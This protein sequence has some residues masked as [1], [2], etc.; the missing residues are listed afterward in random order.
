[1]AIN[2]KNK[3]KMQKIVESVTAD[4]NRAL[5]YQRP[6]FNKFN[7]YYQMYRSISNDNKQNYKGRANLFVP[8]AY[9]TVETIMPKLIGGRPKIE[10]IPREAQDMNSATA[11]TKLTDYQWDMMNMKKITKNW[12][13]QAL[14]YGVGIMK[15]VWDAD[16]NKPKAQEIDLF[17]F[18][19]DPNATSIGNASYIIHRG[20][21]FLYDIKNNPNYNVPAELEADVREDEYK[22]ERD[23]IFGL[24]KP[25]NR[26]IKSVEILEYWGMYD[27]DDEQG[28]VPSLITIA[29]Q[30]YLLRAD[31]N[32]YAHQKKPFIDFH[33]TQVPQMFWSIGEIEP[34]ESLQYEL[35]DTRNQRMDNVNLILNRMWIVDKNADVDEEEL[36]SRPGG[37]VHTMKMKGIEPLVPPDVTASSY[38]EESLI[39][40]DIQQTS[41]VTDVARGQ[42][43]GSGTSGAS[44]DTAT[45]ALILQEASS[46][47]FKYKLDNLEDSIREFGKQLNALNAQFITED[48]AVRVLGAGGPVWESISPDDIQKEYDVMV[49]AGSTQPMNRSVRRAEARE[50]IATIAPFVQSGII[51]LQYFIKHLLQQYDLTEIEEALTQQGIGISGQQPGPGGPPTPQEVG[52]GPQGAVFGGTGNRPS[53]ATIRGMGDR[54]GGTGQAQG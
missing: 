16:E 35:N 41:G 50:L 14:I 33:D 22:V 26:S 1:M 43:T 18:F 2:P 5:E 49:E 21:K 12:V 53:N 30:R 31:R 8:Y 46:N 39:K 34:I 38:N 24:S 47:R 20:E 28:P 54:A 27:F 17:D 36:V 29:N 3:E 25:K 42:G 15:L 45:G 9:S 51:N 19:I 52:G 7:D 40:G 13:K 32:P 4:Y 48:Q 6:L 44:A 37:I 23:A 10:S 11:N